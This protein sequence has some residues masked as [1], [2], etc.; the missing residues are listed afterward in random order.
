MQNVFGGTIMK[1][2][3]AIDKIGSEI[4]KDN[5]IEALFLK[6]SIAR[7]EDDEYSDVDMY[8]VVTTENLDIFLTKR[9]QYMEKYMPLIFWT[10]EN[11]ICPQI[12][13]VFENTLHFDL[14]TICQKNIPQTDDIKIIYDKNSILR[15]YRKEPL[16]ISSSMIIDEINEFSFTIL[17]FE[18]AYHRKDFL[19]AIRLFY[20]QLTR[21]SLITRFIHDKNN[22]KLGLKRLYKFI[23]K[24]L[25]HEYLSIMENATPSNILFAMKKLTD[26]VNKMIEE[27]PE[28]IIKQIN[29][30]FYDLMY[31]KI[32]DLK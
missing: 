29:K 21:A 14:Y 19:W 10:E 30:K 22:S 27:L 1:R 12:V 23:P 25:Y 15:T 5:L 20:A 6:G 9:I 2:Y 17:E 24:E 13:G 4:L 11:F 8:A 16:S 7:N 3:D 31:G 26:L 28:T 18:A 32:I